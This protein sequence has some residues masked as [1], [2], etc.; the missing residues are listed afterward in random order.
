MNDAKWGGQ[1]G[2]EVYPPSPQAR[3]CEEVSGFK[4]PLGTVVCEDIRS[5]EGRA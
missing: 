2:E 3:A 1:R 4:G 5:M